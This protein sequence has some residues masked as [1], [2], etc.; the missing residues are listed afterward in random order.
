MM[1]QEKRI[2]PE[3]DACHIDASVRLAADSELIACVIENLSEKGAKLRIPE[4]LSLPTKFTLHLPF[5]EE[6]SHERE[7]ELR[8]KVGT[9]AGVRFE[10]L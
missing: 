6:C 5:L 4:D 2:A 8:W 9:A 1:I 7:V 10:G 3:R